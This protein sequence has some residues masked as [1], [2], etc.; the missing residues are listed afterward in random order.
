MAWFKC[1]RCKAIY[2]DYYPPDDTC[3]K[4]KK[5]TIRVISNSQHILS[6]GAVDN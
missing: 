5:G 3:L 6:T 4:C 1:K 2:E